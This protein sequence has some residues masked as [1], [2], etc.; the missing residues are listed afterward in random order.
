MGF[1]ALGSDISNQIGQTMDATGQ[2]EVPGNVVGNMGQPT[3]SGKGGAAAPIPGNTIGVNPPG[4]TGGGYNTGSPNMGNNSMP[5][6][7][8]MGGLFGKGGSGLPPSMGTMPMPGTGVQ[9]PNPW[10][11]TQNPLI[12]KGV[13][14][15]QNPM[16]AYDQPMGTMPPAQVNRPTPAQMPVTQPSVAP[17]PGRRTTPI[18]G[19][20]PQ[21]RF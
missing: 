7:A 1:A 9:D 10:A 19:G 16:M 8:G 2:N 18:R 17:A 12:G 15:P 3:G 21:R 4:G 11:R 5:G 14:P 6:F 13:M 20:R